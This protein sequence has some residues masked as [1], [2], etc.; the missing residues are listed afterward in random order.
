MAKKAKTQ[1]QLQPF[2][3]SIKVATR[4]KGRVEYDFLSFK[5]RTQTE[6]FQR[7]QKIGHQL[8]PASSVKILEVHPKGVSVSHSLKAKTSTR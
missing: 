6:A 5:A 7:A 4:G 3:A 1:S 2:Q 8:Y